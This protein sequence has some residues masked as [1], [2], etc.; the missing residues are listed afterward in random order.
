MNINEIAQNAVNV[1][2]GYKSNKIIMDFVRGEA[3]QKVS[4]LMN[5]EGYSTTEKGVE[6]LSC[7]H[8]N[9]DARVNEYINLGLIACY[10]KSIEA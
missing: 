2:E 4:D 1:I 6:L 7:R 3:L 8:K 9:I 10:M 5:A